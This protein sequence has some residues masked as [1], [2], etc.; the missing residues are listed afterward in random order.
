MIIL[1][2]KSSVFFTKKGFNYWSNNFNNCK[3][4][5]NSYLHIINKTF[6]NMLSMNFS[7]SN[8]SNVGK[9]HLILGPMFSGKSTELLRHIRRYNCKKLQT[10]VVAYA[11]D[12]RYITDNNKNILVTHDQNKHPALKAIKISEVKEEIMKYDVIGIDEGQFYE[13]LVEQ[14]EELANKG[15]III[16]AAL[17][18]TYERKPWDQVAKL[19]PK[20]DSIQYITAICYNCSKDASFTA[21]KSKET[22]EV[23]IGGSD[24]YIPCCRNCYNKYE[25]KKQKI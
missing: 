8:N 3:N 15:K 21:R 25:K 1:K 17:S 23:I 9:I 5:N 7:S 20:C 18:S 6:F 19:I 12:D 14:C 4:Y 24:I 11:K 10:T 22:T 16:I 2:S 13:D